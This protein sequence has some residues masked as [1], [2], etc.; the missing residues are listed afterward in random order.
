MPYNKS[1]NLTGVKSGYLGI[2]GGRV[3]TIPSHFCFQARSFYSDPKYFSFHGC[4]QS[5]DNVNDQYARN[6]GIN[7]WA[8]TNSM[9]VLYPQVAKSTLMPMNPQACWDW[10][11]YSDENYGN[12]NG[13]Q[14]TAVHEI[15]L[16]LADYLNN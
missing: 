5:I 14:I 7:E 15:I 2:F 4:N 11:G 10:W 6:T 12:K 1:L 16:G 3:K 9:V 13:K 8:A